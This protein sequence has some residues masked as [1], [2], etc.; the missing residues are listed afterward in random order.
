MLTNCNTLFVATFGAKSSTFER[1]VTTLGLTLR[2]AALTLVTTRSL[3]K[4]L[5][6][7][8]STRAI[9]T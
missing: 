1:N 4:Q 3:K 6:S 7:L 2:K 9:I 8:T 5:T